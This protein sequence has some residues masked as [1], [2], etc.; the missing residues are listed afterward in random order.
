MLEG[1]EL[2]RG[3]LRRCSSASR[4]CRG[5]ASRDL[6]HRRDA[7]RRLPGA[8]LRRV[9]RRQRRVRHARRSASAT[10]RWSRPRSVFDYDMD[11]QT[12]DAAQAA[13]GARRLRPRRS[14]SPSGSSPPRRTACR[15]RSRSSTGRARR[16]TARAPLLLDGYG[17]YGYPYPVDVLV[18]PPEPA[19]PRRGLRHRP[20]PRRR[21]D[22]QA[23][24]RRRPDDEEEEHLHRLHRRAPS[25]SSPQSYTS[26]RPP[27][28]RGRQRG[29]PADGRAWPTCGPTCSRPSCPHVPFVDVHQHHARRLA[30]ADRRRVRG[31]GQPAGARRTTTT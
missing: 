21:R 8:G 20:H 7:R 5:C 12:S 19:R 10:S 29:R 15:S 24:A 16:A 26:P 9:P 18:E 6:A 27:G 25:T 1:V 13:A 28:H 3:P 22:G 30:A 17:S 4:G 2:L 23:L 31:V 11:A 14:T